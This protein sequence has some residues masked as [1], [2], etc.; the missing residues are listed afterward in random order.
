MKKLILIVSLVIALMVGGVVSYLTYRQAHTVGN[1]SDYS[2]INSEM[3]PQDCVAQGG[4]I[5]DTIGPAPSGYSP[6]NVLGK[7]AG[8]MCPCVC[9]KNQASLVT[10]T[11]ILVQNNPGMEKD[12]WYLAYEKPGAPALSVKLLFTSTSVCQFTAIHDCATFLPTADRV[13]VEGWQS[14]NEITVRTLTVLES[15]KTLNDV[16]SWQTYRNESLGYSIGYPGDWEAEESDDTVYISAKQWR[17]MPEGGGSVDISVENKTL[18]Q[19]I[20]DYNSSDIFN[21]Y[22]LSKILKQ[23]EYT[24][25]SVGAYK[26][27]AST[28]IGLERTYI[29]IPYNNRAYIIGYHNYDD[30]HLEIL[31]T[32]K[33]ISPQNSQLAQCI[34]EWQKT[35]NLGYPLAAIQQG[36]ISVGYKKGTSEDEIRAF[37]QSK[38]L[39]LDWYTDL[40]NFVT[41]SVPSGKEIEWICNLTD[42]RLPSVK[43][44]ED[45]LVQ[46]AHTVPKTARLPTN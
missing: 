24:I 42:N 33:F 7:V 2:S 12:A 13:S 26:L 36:V 23:E 3:S 5:V 22:A 38:G 1:W 31:K 20:E 17:D 32:F 11:G 21:G 39:T 19:F 40:V 46:S 16:S 25:D 35:E 43:A 30:I 10:L 9:L 6:K 45:A 37:I 15:K 14:G 8:M 27:T 29:F 28:A 18:D 4:T 44:P 41:V 34:S